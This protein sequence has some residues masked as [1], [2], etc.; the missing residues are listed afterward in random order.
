MRLLSDD[1]LAGQTSTGEPKVRPIDDMT[2]SC[3]NAATGA[4]EKLSYD[5]LDLFL[6]SLRQLRAVSEACFVSCCDHVGRRR[7]VSGGVEHV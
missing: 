7:V 4:Q 3:V 2:A 6:E 5:T 1:F